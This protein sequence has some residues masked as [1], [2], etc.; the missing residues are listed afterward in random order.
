MP[1]LRLILDLSA[2]FG[3]LLLY[4]PVMLPVAVAYLTLHQLQCRLLGIR[5]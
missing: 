1:R 4:A 3:P 5:P 2:R